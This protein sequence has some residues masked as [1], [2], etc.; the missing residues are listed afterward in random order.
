MESTSSLQLPVSATRLVP[1]SVPLTPARRRQLDQLMVTLG[2]EP[3]LGL[4]WDLLDLALIHPSVS[5]D[6]NYEHLEFVGDAVVRLAT[7]EFLTE[8]YNSAK[9]GD[10]AAIRSV[11]VSDRTLAEIA[12][13]Y[14]FDRYLLVASSA[15]GDNAGANTR[16]ADALEAVMA[17]FYL[18]CQNLTLVRPW[19]DPHWQTRAEEIRQDPA[20]QNY[21]AALQEWTQ[22]HYK[23]LPDYRVTELNIAHGDRERFSA[24]VW[25]QGQCLGTGIGHSIKA[26][27]QAA[28]KIAFLA[29]AEP[30]VPA[31]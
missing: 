11:L 9:V 31:S 5:A 16:L 18:S 27:Q 6:R 28:A 3:P 13:S 21:K 1:D 19:L 10:L 15:A 14:S 12:K 20:R 2:I 23:V 30:D 25:L 17:A 4:R 22:G 8:V 7:A 29:L 26:A 24:E